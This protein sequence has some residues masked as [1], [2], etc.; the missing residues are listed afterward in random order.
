[1][2]VGKYSSIPK[3]PG[4]LDIIP[5]LRI[6]LALPTLSNFALSPNNR[7]PGVFLEIYIRG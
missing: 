3:I 4:I 6:E 1:M 2:I 7:F 5:I